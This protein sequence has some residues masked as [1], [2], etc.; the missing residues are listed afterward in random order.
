M[1]FQQF[2]PPEPLHHHVRYFWTLEQQEA[3]PKTFRTIA[4]GC[5]GLI[6]QH[7]TGGVSD[8]EGKPWPKLL[9]YGQATQA[10]T[11]QTRGP[12]R[13]V[14]ACLYP[15]TERSIFHVKA[16]ELTDTC[17]DVGLLSGPARRLTEHLLAPAPLPAQLAGLAQALLA[18][19][20]TPM[21][22]PDPGI[23]YA[24]AQ[25]LRTQGNIALPALQAT[26]PFSERSFQRKFKEHVGLSPKLFARICQFQSSL[27]QLRAM[28]YDKL[29]DLAFAN[30]YADQSHHIRS[31][32]E[33]AGVSPGQYI[34]HTQQV[35]DNLTEVR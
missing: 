3:T 11:L 9:L 30:E 5:P 8:A 26:L 23:Q 28:T 12:F 13:L 27:G 20:R 21:A 18:A 32:K 1:Y 35:L 34:H 16:D 22:P 31:F 33:F 17:L 7:A 4:D 29:S 25:I 19:L 24:L 6:L 15:G 2:A 14:G 10:S